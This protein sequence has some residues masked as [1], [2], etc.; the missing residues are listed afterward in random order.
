MIYIFNSFFILVTYMVCVFLG[1]N[2]KKFNITFS[3]LVGVEMALIIGLRNDVGADWKSYEQLYSYFGNK[4]S[5]NF[6]NNRIEIGYKVLNYILWNLNIPYWGLNLFMAVLT[7]FFFLKACL[8]FENDIFLYVYLY[9]CFFF[10]YFAMNQTRQAL[11]MAIGIYAVSQLIKG[12]SKKF[13]CLI[14]LATMFHYV[15]LVY[16]VLLF[17]RKLE[18]NNGLVIKVLI[19]AIG[20][21]LASKIV[22]E[23]VKHTIYSFYFQQGYEIENYNSIYMNTFIRVIFLLLCLWRYEYMEKG[24]RKSVLYSMGIFCVYTQILTCIYSLFGRVTTPFFMGFIFLFPDMLD[25]YP[26]RINVRLGYG[27]VK[28][29]FIQIAFLIMVAI[30]QIMYFKMSGTVVLH[31]QYEF[32][33]FKN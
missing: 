26:K 18:I 20:C 15:S 13:I 24:Y 23:I 30:Y 16:L 5:N 19:G 7:M 10:F 9:V 33:F 32:V 4:I 28:T 8:E 3:I 27:N 25:T 31:N 29:S 14:L 12:N 17:T 22:F 21:F 1:L 2:K 6:Q 11:A